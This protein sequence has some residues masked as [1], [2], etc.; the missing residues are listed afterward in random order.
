MPVFTAEIPETH[1][2]INRPVIKQVIDDVLKRFKEIPYR[3]FRFLG[4]S[5]QLMTP[6]SAIDSGAFNRALSDNY[7]DVEVEDVPDDEYGRSYTT[8]QNINKAII[9]CEKTKLD[10]YPIYQNRKIVISLRIVCSSRVR[11]NGLVTR[12][13]QGMH[14]SETMFSHQ[15]SYDY[16]LPVPCTVLLGEIY[17]RM[18]GMHGYG[19][20]FVQWL[21]EIKQ[22]HIQM[23]SRLDGKSPVL[24]V[25]ENAVEA[26]SNLVEHEQEPRKEKDEN[27]GVWAIDLDIELRYQRP[28]VIRASYPPII[29]NQF[30]PDIWFNKNKTFD[31]KSEAATS[32]L[33]NMA[34]ERFKWNLNFG[35]PG[36]GDLGVKEPFFDDWAK[37]IHNRNMIKLLTSLI[38][39]EDCNPNRLFNVKNDIVDYVFPDEI[40]ETFKIHPSALFYEGAHLFHIKAYNHAIPIRS[41]CLTIDEDLNIAV[42]YD[43]DPRGYYHIVFCINRDPTTISDDLW[44]EFLCDKEALIMYFSLFGDKYRDIL[45]AYIAEMEDKEACFTKD[46]IDEIIR[47][48]IKDGPGE[49]FDN[50]KLYV[51][52][53]P[54]RTKVGYHV[55]GS[56][57]FD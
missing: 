26:K 25:R 48:I 20:D 16:D 11:M 13:K 39:V 34:L 46:V 42:D 19:I 38:T 3:E 8:T 18:E 50:S 44:Y 31:Y 41:D 21:K 32:S 40:L 36:K 57:R 6:G 27:N 28:N 30:L 33:G 54:R 55:I 45:L 17:G 37:E 12:I 43:L 1:L 10:M 14:Q 5:E 2:R 24:G 51:D 49:D 22:D 29:H 52:Y 7:V 23:F 47:E 56:R 53:V 9:R 15:I 35:I 4:D